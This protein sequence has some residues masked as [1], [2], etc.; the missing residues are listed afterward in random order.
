MLVYM[1]GWSRVQFSL[2]Q[3]MVRKLF[4]HLVGVGTVSLWTVIIKCV[5]HFSA[6][7]ANGVVTA[8]TNRHSDVT[9]MQFLNSVIEWS[10]IKLLDIQTTPCRC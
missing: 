4:G 7:Y 9:A 10:A 6:N 5:T 8:E 2:D 1:R 3:A